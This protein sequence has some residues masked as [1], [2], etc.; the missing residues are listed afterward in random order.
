MDLLVR[1]RALLAAAKVALSFSIVACSAA[2]EDPSPQDDTTNDYLSKK[3]DSG[4]AAAHDC[5]SNHAPTL[6]CGIAKTP[7]LD[8]GKASNDTLACCTTLVR[9]TQSDA[10][11]GWM[12]LSASAAKDPNVAGCCD[13][14]IANAWNWDEDAG[15]TVPYDL[16]SSCC[17]ATGSKA[18]ACTPWGPP[19]P[20]A[21]TKLRREEL[22]ALM[23]ADLLAEVA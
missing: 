10:G 3:K 5:G 20:P 16:V 14:L 4:A 12:T 19:A 21:I 9:G 17:Q 15:V 2:V 18:M 6:A 1:R 23:M 22:V 8:A 11:E 13:A 7:A